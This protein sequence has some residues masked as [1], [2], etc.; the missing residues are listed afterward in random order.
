MV[1]LLTFA[2]KKLSPTLKRIKNE[3]VASGWF[4][5]VLAYDDDNIRKDKA[6]WKT[7]QHLYE[8][9]PRGFGVLDMEAIFDK[10]NI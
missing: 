1:V 8:E 5:K 2:D 7:Y 6:Y 10:K 9:N 3:A 4:D